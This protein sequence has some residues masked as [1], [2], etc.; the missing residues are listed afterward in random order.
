MAEAPHRRIEPRDEGERFLIELLDSLWARY[1]GRVEPARRYEAL[2]ERQGGLFRNDHLAFRTLAWQDPASGV[3]TVS[4]LFEALGYSSAGCYEFP[5]KKLSAVHF[6]HSNPALPKLFVSQLRT[7]EL[8]AEGRAAAARSLARQR[9]PFPDEA[10][11]R[12]ASLSRGAPS[13]ASRGALLSRCLSFFSQRPWPAPEKADVLA[14]DRESQY[15]AWVL[16]HGSDVNH[17]TA[18]VEDIEKAVADLRAD[19]VKMKAEIEGAPGSPLRQSST[20]AVV[21]PVDVFDGGKPGKLDWT[22]AYFELA[23]RPGR[24]DPATGKKVRFEGFLGGQATNLFDMT[25]RP[26]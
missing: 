7:W 15:A 26:R 1:R 21:L 10:L 4:R 9:P 20:E 18:A 5:D 12:L 19:G 6:A 13:P 22:Y 8:S 16:V 11:A 2:V 23:E 14:L 25:A 17:F 24:L 3:A